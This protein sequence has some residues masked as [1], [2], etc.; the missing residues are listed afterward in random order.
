MKFI[1]EVVPYIIIL[2]VVVLIRTYI[3]TPVIVDGESMSNTLEDGEVLILKK[4]D[5]SFDRFDIVVFNYDNE[6]LIKRII[7]LPGESVKY[8]DGILYIND[9]EVEDKFGPLTYDFSIERLDI[10]TIPEG[11][12]F[13]LGDNR[14]NSSDSR[15]IGL[16]SEKDI[17]GT[18]SFS[19]WPI[20]TIK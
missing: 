4:Y 9:K 13:A 14:K 16:I 11:Y 12:Y 5:R 19:I 8:K 20:K 1:K 17:T 2:A 10:T 6:K 7:G 15:I 18:T 3:V